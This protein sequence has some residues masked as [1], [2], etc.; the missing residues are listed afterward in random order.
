VGADTAAR[1]AL[2][3]S[4]QTPLHYWFDWAPIRTVF[5]CQVAIKFEHKT[6]KGCSGGVP[7]EWGVYSVLGNTLGLPQVY[8][9]GQQGNF[10][11]MVRPPSWEHRCHV[12][13]G[14]AQGGRG[15]S[16]CGSDGDIGV[17]GATGG[18]CA[19]RLP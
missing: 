11:I 4:G 18:C 8:Y 5:V 15:E 16:L 6:S 19:E 1:L 12:C 13:T 17:A 3:D 2:M 9:K 7:H 14:G 10:H